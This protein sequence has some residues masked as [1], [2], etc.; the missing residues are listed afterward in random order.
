MKI[1]MTQR[2]SMTHYIEGTPRQTWDAWTRPEAISQWWHLPDSTAPLYGLE[3]DV[4]AGGNYI[5]TSIDNETGDRSVSGG[6]FHEVVP[7][8]RL[9]FT[10][11]VPKLANGNLPLITIEIDE[12]EDGSYIQLTLEG[13]SGE[14]GDGAFYD[15]WDQALVRLR[16][17]VAKQNSDES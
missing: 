12:T 9:V 4:R 1:D 8:H 2:F 11:G 3:Y 10:W 15:I 5:Y 16:E 17:F 6:V 7:P 13:F 14:P